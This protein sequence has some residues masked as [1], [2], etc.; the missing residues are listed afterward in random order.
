MT[1]MSSRAR[2]LVLLLASALA[3]A[4][5][6]RTVNQVLADPSRY[7]DREVKLSGNVV[8]S[9]SILNQGAYRIDDGTG[10]LWIVSQKGVPR[11]TA[12]VTVTGT[13]REGFN[14]GSL[15]GRLNLPP[16]VAAGVVMMESSHTAK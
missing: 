8:D 11:T 9:Y 12:R 15:G 7:R 4:C 14:L 1:Q 16:G 5:G 13:I 10:Q 2:I 6:T 3:S